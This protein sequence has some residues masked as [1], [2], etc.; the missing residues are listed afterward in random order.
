MFNKHTE[1][2]QDVCQRIELNKLIFQATNSMLLSFDKIILLTDSALIETFGDRFKDV[3]LLFWDN[4]GCTE[5][6]IEGNCKRI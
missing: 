5:I 4:A 3:Q 2:M 6:E 1:F